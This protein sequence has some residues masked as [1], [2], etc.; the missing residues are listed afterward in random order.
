MLLAPGAG[1]DRNH[2]A[3]VAIDD[4][5][6]PIPVARMDFAYRRAGRKA[7]DRP[8]VLVAAVKDEAA[9][10]AADTGLPP[11]RLVLGGRSLGGRMCSMAVAFGLPALG[12]YGPELFPTSLRGRANGIIQ[13]VSLVGS[14]VGLLVAGGLADR[15]G[16]FGPAMAVVGAGP[17][18]LAV[19]LVAVFPETAGREL[20]EINP[21][22]RR[23]EE[24]PPTG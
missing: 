24:P 8:E 21:E 5:L 9:A 7:P 2:S 22:D 15:W 19:L 16:R 12:V 10:L 11:E 17:L 1:A 4:A 23:P 3:L 14:A 20:E 13:V 18:L 6:R